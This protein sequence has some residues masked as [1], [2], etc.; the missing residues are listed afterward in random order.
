MQHSLASLVAPVGA[1]GPVLGRHACLL[2]GH[3]ADL[4]ELLLG[5]FLTAVARLSL[6]RSLSAP[7]LTEAAL[8]IAGGVTWL[9]E[10]L[11]R[12]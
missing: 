1:R 9:A 6:G 4:V 11:A 2:A 12:T 10:F 8:G 3:V 7:L 5:A